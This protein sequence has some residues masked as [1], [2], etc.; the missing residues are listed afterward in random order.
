M[1]SESRV[2]VLLQRPQAKLP[3]AEALEKKK[4]DRELLLL[5]VNMTKLRLFVNDGEHRREVGGASLLLIHLD[6]L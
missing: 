3:N 1:L 5:R 2:T 6:L 4:K